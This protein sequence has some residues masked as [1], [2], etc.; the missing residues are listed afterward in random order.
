MRHSRCL[1]LCVRGVSPCRRR[2]SQSVPQGS[3][4]RPSSSMRGSVSQYILAAFAFGMNGTDGMRRLL[5]LYSWRILWLDVK[6]A[7]F[8]LNVH[9]R[10][11]D[12][13]ASR[14]NGSTQAILA[15]LAPSVFCG[16]SAASKYVVWQC[17][18]VSHPLYFPYVGLASGCRF[19]L[20]RSSLAFRFFRNWWYPLLRFDF[21]SACSVRDFTLRLLPR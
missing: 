21:P 14:G 3:H 8:F 7:L 12:D 15:V 6:Q 16:D 19:A 5:F 17:I 10:H 1:C 18:H 20:R 9:G 2:R 11:S 4:F 13:T